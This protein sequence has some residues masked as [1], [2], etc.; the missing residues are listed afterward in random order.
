MG[1][2][3]QNRL[4]KNHKQESVP[5]IQKLKFDNEDMYETRLEAQKDQIGLVRYNVPKVRVNC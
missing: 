3:E 2:L 4:F 1:H 5:K